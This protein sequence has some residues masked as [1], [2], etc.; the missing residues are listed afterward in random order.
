MNFAVVDLGTNTFN[1]LIASVSNKK[2]KAE[3]VTKQFV[4]L[5]EG[6]INEGKI[7]TAAFDRGINTLV[8]FRM[9]AN[10]YNCHEVFGIATSAIRNAENGAD[11]ISRAKELANID[12]QIIDGDIEA[13]LIYRG[14]REAVD[15]EDDIAV[16][17]DVG[18]GS[19]EF[20]ICNKEKIFW[21]QSF[22]V[23]AARLFEQFHSTDPISIEDISAIESYLEDILAPVIQ[24]AKELNV[25]E[26]IGSS[27]AFTSFAQMI[28]CALGGEAL[29]RDQKGYDFKMMNYLAIHQR[30]L[31]ST[32][33]ERLGMQG[34]IK[35]RAPMIVVG[36]ILVNFVVSTLGIE[37]FK[38]SRY[39]LKEG[40]A[41]A[42]AEDKLKI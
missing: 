35:E 12:I 34:L 33:K 6:G 36:T 30:L 10:E 38:L 1:L 13:D 4:K 41:Q 23:G 22:E 39:S 17:M 27:G 25:T 24:K 26:L 19:T 21:K 32:L 8:E 20:I 40:V 2:F 11:F 16:V 18:G 15:F 42:Y 28:V 9:I 37:K 7:Q 29:V 3:Y 14:A 31:Q 5:G